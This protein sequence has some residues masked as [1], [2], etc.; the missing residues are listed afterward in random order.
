MGVII[1]NTT[2]S[3][4]P[5]CSED[6]DNKEVKDTQKVIEIVC[7]HFF[8]ANCLRT[9]NEH[10]ERAHGALRCGYCNQTYGEPIKPN[11]DVLKKRESFDSA[12]ETLKQ[13]Y[14]YDSSALEAIDLVRGVF[15]DLQKIQHDLDHIEI[16]I[17][18]EEK[19]DFFCEDI[20]DLVVNH[21]EIQDPLKGTVVHVIAA[22]LFNDGCLR[23]IE[24]ECRRWTGIPLSAFPEK[25]RKEGCLVRFEGFKVCVSSDYLHRSTSTVLVNDIVTKLNA[26]VEYYDALPG[27]I[28]RKVSGFASS[29]FGYLRG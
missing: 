24:S 1:R 7:G 26:D 29:V 3:S 21:K 4:C 9:W 22:I 6:Y 2:Y 20:R 16:D 25:I 18:Q 14:S 19:K 11:P 8:H 15:A 28:Y 13:N 12:L 10:Q 5:I 23:T 27:K 17:N